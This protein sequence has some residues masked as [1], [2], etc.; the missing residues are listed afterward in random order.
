MRGNITRRGKNSWQLKFDGPWSM[1]SDSSVMRLC[2][3][4]T[5]MRRKN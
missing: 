2:E 5:K 4:P 3:A 1:S